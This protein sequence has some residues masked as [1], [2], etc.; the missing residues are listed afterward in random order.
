[1]AILA[2]VSKGVIKQKPITFIYGAGG[3]GKDTFAAGYPKPL[4]VD[5][6]K[7]TGHLNIDRLLPGTH[8]EIFD[9]VKEMAE[10]KHDYKTLNVSGMDTWEGLAWKYIMAKDGVDT[11]A[12]AGGGYGGGYKVYIQLCQE[13]AA[14]LK[15]CQGRGMYVNLIGHEMVQ[16]YNDPTLQTYDRYRIKMYE[17]PKESAAKFWFDFCDIVLFVKKKVYQKSD[18]RAIDEGKHYIYTQGRAAFDAKSRYALPFEMELNAEK[19]L[20]ALEKGPESA[21]A[22]YKLCNELAAL[23]KDKNLQKKVYERIE[24]E[25]GNANEL[26]STLEVIKGLEKE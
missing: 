13:L 14:M 6:E 18:N 24:K 15:V 25:K 22:V 7:G 26:S 4:T 1:M 21:E 3:L 19:F 5:V 10:S 16:P 11:M 8:Q 2:N 9:A 17:G 12:K 20:A 23:V